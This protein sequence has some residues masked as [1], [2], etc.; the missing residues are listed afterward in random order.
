MQINLVMELHFLAPS[1]ASVE[2]ALAEAQVLLSLTFFIDQK[3]EVKKI[4]YHRALKRPQK[5]TAR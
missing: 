5:R 2:S 3:T 1:K 4:F